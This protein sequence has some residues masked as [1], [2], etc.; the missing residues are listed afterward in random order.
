MAFGAWYANKHFDVTGKALDYFKN[1]NFSTELM[2]DNC[3]NVL[4]GIFKKF[5]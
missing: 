1:K 2:L 5:E 3:E 4:E